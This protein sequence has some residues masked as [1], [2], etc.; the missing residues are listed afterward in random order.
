LA[1]I[2]IEEQNPSENSR[3]YALKLLQESLELFQRCLNVQELQYTQAAQETQQLRETEQADPVPVDSDM[4]DTS[5][6]A[7]WAAIVRPVTKGTL[8]DTCIAQLDTLS[9]LCAL[10]SVQG[11]GKLAWIEEMYHIALHEKL[12]AYVEGA[13]RQRDAALAKAKFDCAFA[14]AAYRNGRMAL[15][16]YEQELNSAFSSIPELDLS[17]DA[18]S[19]W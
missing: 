3:D 13:D 14:E 16:T 9:A 10:E 15:A 2:T 12:K 4:S 8:L 11:H 19:L 1:E 6:N 7:V 17:R 18:Q 5:E